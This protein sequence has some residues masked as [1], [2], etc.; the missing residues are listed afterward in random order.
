MT[1]TLKC[2]HCQS[3]FPVY[4]LRSICEKC[5]G[6]LEFTADLPEAGELSFSDQLGFWRYKQVLPPVNHVVSLGEG[7]TPM[8][9]AERLAEAIGLKDLY[10]KDETRN[11]T[12][13]YRD[14]AAAFLTSNAIDRGFEY[15]GL[16]Q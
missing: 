3:E 1:S 10:L 5:G 7:G 12:N 11:P 16:R 4:P 2:I 6:T 14:R 9:K 13:S 8:H 15:T